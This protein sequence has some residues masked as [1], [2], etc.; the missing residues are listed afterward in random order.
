VQLCL[1]ALFVSR[2]QDALLIE[3]LQVNQVSR[4]QLKALPGHF[5][6]FFAVF[7]EGNRAEVAE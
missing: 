3:R 5:F 2:K 7:P 4:R 6:Q 1:L